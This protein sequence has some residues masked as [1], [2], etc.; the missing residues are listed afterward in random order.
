MEGI[1][2]TAVLSIIMCCTDDGNQCDVARTKIFN[3]IMP[4]DGFNCI[5]E[6]FQSPMDITGFRWIL[7]LVQVTQIV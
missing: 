5:V 4:A 6:I 2:I 7:S 1:F 3:E